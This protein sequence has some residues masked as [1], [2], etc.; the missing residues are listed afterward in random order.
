[1][2]VLGALRLCLSERER[3]RGERERERE[4]EALWVELWAGP[5]D[6]LHLIQM[7]LIAPTPTLSLPKYRLP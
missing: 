4:R 1:M 3:E 6:K 5:T 7:A 2:V